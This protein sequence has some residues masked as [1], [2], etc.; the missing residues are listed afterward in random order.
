MKNTILATAVLAVGLSAS[1]Q[2]IYI[3]STADI[4]N[5]QTTTTLGQILSAPGVPIADNAGVSFQLFGSLTTS[6]P[7]GFAPIGQVFNTTSNPGIFSGGYIAGPLT[8]YT[9]PG[10]T[11]AGTFSFQ[12]EA[13]NNAGGTITSYANASI[14]GISPNVVTVTL[15]NPATPLNPA[16]DLSGFQSFALI[17]EPSTLALGAVGAAGLLIL[18]RRRQ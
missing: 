12:I 6:S 9:I 4:R 10:A 17:P 3:D 5:G 16:P 2:S 13:G 18:R 15:F 1:A 11:A 8:A 14:K 7:S